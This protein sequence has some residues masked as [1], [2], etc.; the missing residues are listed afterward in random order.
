V[1]NSRRNHQELEAVRERNARMVSET[2]ASYVSGAPSTYP[3]GSLFPAEEAIQALGYAA[4][5]FSEVGHPDRDAIVGRLQWMM[6]TFSEVATT[7]P[8]VDT[9]QTF[10]ETR[11]WLGR[12]GYPEAEGVVRQAGLDLMKYWDQ[13]GAHDR[14]IKATMNQ[15]DG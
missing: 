10:Y 7:E 11:V 4:L 3:D 2:V 8:T 15:A 9:I 5:S 6:A 13:N 1:R 12:H 14:M